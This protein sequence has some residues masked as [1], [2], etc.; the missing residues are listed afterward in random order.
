M[1]LKKIVSFVKENSLIFYIIAA[2]IL[3]FIAQKY[4]Y[5]E[6]YTKEKMGCNKK[7]ENLRPTHRVKT[8][9]SLALFPNLS[10]NSRIKQKYL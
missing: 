3:L 7:R 8:A 1:Y 4:L 2:V 6:S 5:K 9:P 10:A